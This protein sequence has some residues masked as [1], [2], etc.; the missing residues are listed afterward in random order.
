MK[1]LRL[2]LQND[3]PGERRDQVKQKVCCVPR[4]N[5]LLCVGIAATFLC[6]VLNFIKGLHAKGC[7]KTSNLKISSSLFCSGLYVKAIV[8]NNFLDGKELCKGS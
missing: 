6:Y 8:H 1:V 3:L 5:I 7:L 2:T 4:M